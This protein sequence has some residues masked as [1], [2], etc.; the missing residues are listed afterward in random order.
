LSNFTNKQKTMGLFKKNIRELQ[1]PKAN[2]KHIKSNLIRGEMKS[3][4]Y[5]LD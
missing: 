2:K 4:N 5:L 3:E 1:Y